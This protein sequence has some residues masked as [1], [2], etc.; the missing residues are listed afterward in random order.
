MSP[1]RIRRALLVAWAVVSCL[2]VA[3]S[4]A[5]VATDPAGTVQAAM[6]AVTSGGIAKFTDYMCAAKR[7]DPLTA[8]GA[9]NVQALTAA[10]VKAEDVM[11][12]MSISFANVTVSATSQTTTTATVHLTADSSVDFDRE[13]MR[14][15]MK[16]VLA[17]EAKPTD[18]ATV[19]RVL[20]A[21]SASLTRTRHVDQSVNL[22]NEGG[23]WLVC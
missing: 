1:N 16:T 2:F 3:C 6:S 8:L 18:D 13:R 14:P 10:G 23:R 11:A 4:S 20:T 9:S 19:G 5:P 21:M 22:V 17:A 7:A 12:A 15:I